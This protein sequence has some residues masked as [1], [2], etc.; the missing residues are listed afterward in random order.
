MIIKLTNVTKD[1]EG[2]VLINARHIM[3]VFSETKDVDDAI[4]TK[5][6]VYSVTKEAWSVKESPDE[7]YDMIKECNHE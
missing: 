6:V 7:I 2:P 5:T 1:F 4:E 3:S